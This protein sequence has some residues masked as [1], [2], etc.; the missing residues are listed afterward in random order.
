MLIIIVI[1][2]YNHDCNFRCVKT[3]CPYQKRDVCIHLPVDKL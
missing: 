1:L 3:F 2:D